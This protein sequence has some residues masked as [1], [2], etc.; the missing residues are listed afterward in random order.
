MNCLRKIFTIVLSVFALVANAQFVDVD[1][2][3]IAR[4]TL[5]P[6]Y[7]TMV[8][9]PDDYV[10]YNYKVAIE[11]PEFVPMSTAEVARYRLEALRDSLPPFPVVES[12][13][14]IS[15]KR[16]QLDVSFT[17]VVFSEGR[18]MR[19]NSFKLVVN[20]TLDIA[21]AMSRLNT[22][23]TAGERY[24]K[25]SVLDSGRWV[26]IA[27]EESG[28]HKITS[29]ELRKMG[30]KNPEK[31]RLFGYGGRVLPETN[32]HQ[33]PDDL[34]EI[35]LWR[36][37]GYVLF[38][39]NG[40]IRWE[41]SNGRFVHRQNVYSKYSYYFLN[42]SDAEPLP[43]PKQQLQATSNNVLD[44]YPDY[45][46]YEKEAITLATYGRILLDSYN[47]ASGRSVSY[48]FSL[49]G[50]VEG[51]RA[52]V[53]VS[54]GSNAT[55]ASR[56]AVDVNGAQIGSLGISQ[57]GSTDHGRI[58][59]VSLVA[60]S[61]LTASTVI[62]L[63]HTV[64]DAS[65]SGHLDYLR[66]NFMR[67]LKMRGS[68]CEFRGNAS[69]G[70]AT[71]KIAQATSDTHVWLVTD[72]AA[73]V[74][75]ES[76]LSDGTLTVVAP[77]SYKEQLVAV[78]VKGNFSAVKMV[79]EVSKQ[80]LH[81]MSSTDMIIIVPSNGLFLE[82]ANRLAEAHRKNDGITVEVVTAQQ[83]YNEFSSGT[84]DATAYRRLMKMLYDRAESADCAPKYLLL[85]G[86]GVTDN[87]LITYPRMSSDNLLLT[88]QSENSV[89]AVRSYVLEDYYALLDDGEGGDFLRNKIDIAVGR[90]PAQ[91]VSDASA[92][93]DKLVA[94]IENRTPGAWQNRIVLMGDD[95]DKSMPN[96]HMKDAE[97]VAS[98][99]AE[100][101][102]AFMLNRIYWDDYP[103]EVLSTGNS[104]PMATQAIYD[105]L[106]EGALIA[107]YSGH[108]SANLLS[109]EQ[110]WKASD[111]SAL[112]SPRV[113]FW[114]TASCDI[115]PFDMGDGSLAEAAI[116]N[117][118][119]GAIGLLTTT[120]TVLQSY[121]AVINQAFMRILLAPDAKGDYPSVGDA[122]RM[123]KCE[124]IANGND[125]SE[126][127]L[128]YVLIG[129]PAL[130][131]Q[132]PRYRVVVDKFN[133]E[134]VSA[135]GK[136]QAGGTLLVEGYVAKPDGSVAADFTGTI[137]STLF[138]CIETV[139]T[140]DNTGLGKFDYIAYPKRL[141]AGSDS[142]VAGRFKIKIPVPMDI[143]YRND[144]GMLNLFAIDTLGVSA[145]GYYNNF[146][147][148]GTAPSLGDDGK[149]PQIKMYLNTPDFID[150]DEVN[151]TPCL[152]VELFDENGINT[153]GTGV[154][155]DIMAIVD[156]DKFHTYNLN[157][158]FVP[159]VGDYRS[160]TIEFPLSQLGEGEHTLL[161]RAWDL[162]NN[163]SVDTLTFVVVPG[164]APEFIDIKVAP[165]PVEY[166]QKATFVLAHNRPHSN[167]DVTIELFNLQ[168]VKMWQHSE[169]MSSAST[170]C[171]VEWDVTTSG[172]RPLPTGVYIYRASLASEGGSM[173]TKTE[174][175][176]VLNNK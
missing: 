152:F 52:N 99:I 135:V 91:N 114:V 53:D 80:N 165:N 4:D 85:F 19:I 35:P 29:A 102:P 159:S 104:Y 3:T 168:G 34:Q 32:I 107:N 21:S 112:T 101:N 169:C 82:A 8:E 78:N 10:M 121:N 164:L 137:E 160:G 171:V 74:E 42:E 120:R 144:E 56:L 28:V 13:V 139:S 175:I 59:S 40:T 163:S 37:S 62:K 151:S 9:L 150:G 110:T 25:S 16:G 65:L 123:A 20:R 149:G 174:K 44:T 71:F 122:M 67:T 134:D 26:R 116:L 118:Q 7:S 5:L 83:V 79:E 84:P 162:F 30:F 2:E 88:Y 128:E 63:T 117:P 142:V 39:A 136:V 124:I 100:T 119:G 90:I 27:V 147:V 47:Y 55:S 143:S 140:R 167:L 87:R 125:L 161:L 130:R 133:G 109:H 148:G 166:G 17:P 86:D 94:Y 18:F 157:S 93:V 92:V 36:E 23:A 70:N 77:A 131:L 54:F 72:Q 89:S 6:R 97:A 41:Y 172:G 156:N 15:A 106:G 76:Q 153:V 96:Q 141:F 64:S 127:K 95:G 103:M 69:S 170:Q 155:H 113:P 173:Q 176:I 108:G 38:F 145:Q 132:I 24:A 11:Y 105:R 22:R 138:D 75:L 158:A 43:F 58:S 81:A 48:K 50:V 46:L 111:M 154:G 51:Q 61:G 68:D 126:N 1:W 98:H 45:A 146:I 129:D 12:V 33:Q 14:G 60:Q 57:A 31:V 115:G 49:D 66:L 73:T